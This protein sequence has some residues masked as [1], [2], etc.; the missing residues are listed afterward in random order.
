MPRM[1]EGRETGRVCS[2]PYAIVACSEAM[3]GQRGHGVVVCS[4]MMNLSVSGNRERKG[5]W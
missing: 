2:P 3:L 4:K 1:W 5:L